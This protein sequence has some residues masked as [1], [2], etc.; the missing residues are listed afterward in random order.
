MN[1]DKEERSCFKCPSFVAPDNFGQQSAVYGRP[2][3]AGT[4]LKFGAIISTQKMDQWVVEAAAEERASNCTGYMQHTSI[5]DMKVY[6]NV[7]IGQPP[8]DPSPK[9]RV[10]TCRACFFHIPATRAGEKTGLGMGVCSKFGKAIPDSRA[11]EMA[12][13]CRENNRYTPTQNEDPETHRQNLLN[14]LIID[15]ILTKYLD[16]AG[17]P[18][19]I[20]NA[21][22]NSEPST[23]ETD[24]DVTPAQE[25]AGI[26]AWRKIVQG[27]RHVFMPV[28]RRDFFSENEQSKIPA[29]GDAEHPETYVDHEGLTYAVSA[30]WFMLD[31]T[32]AL[33]GVAGTGKTEFYRYM[34]W[35]MQVPFERI[36]I[37]ADSEVDDLVGKMHFENNETVFKDGRLVAAW[38]KPNVVCIDEPNVGPPD[39][40]HLMRSL[41][42]NSKQLVNDRNEG[43]V[44]K[45]NQF[46]FLGMAMNPAWDA[47]NV[48]AQ[49]LGDADGSRLYHIFVGLPP[50]SLER[51]IITERCKVD[52][53]DIEDKDLDIIMSVAKT[54]REMSD[55]QELNITWGI[56]NQ[57]KVARALQAFDLAQ[58]YRIGVLDYLEPE[59]KEMVLNVVN[60]NFRRFRGARSGRL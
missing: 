3:S 59:T 42:D 17:Q 56:R 27:K 2:T 36:S 14:S 30:A 58:A 31:E 29:T 13:G 32:P 8:A 40:W 28:F 57:I 12:K 25:A 19:P 49:Q 43:E 20:Q 48:G 1:Y 21:T 41:T 4:C 24:R 23:Y 51:K 33:Y 52:G 18:K 34:A 53:F 6:L 37:T 45:R 22:E 47:R 46:A 38:K 50:E 16:L 10:G 35:L 9:K 39:V 44:I 55:N 60:E 7:G 54:L 15:P 11:T 26:R 5:S